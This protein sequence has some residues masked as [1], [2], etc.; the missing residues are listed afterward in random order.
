MAQNFFITMG[1]MGMS[2]SS[3]PTAASITVTRGLKIFED[4]SNKLLS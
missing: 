4:V 2:S 1:D 3:L